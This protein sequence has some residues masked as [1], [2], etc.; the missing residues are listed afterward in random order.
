MYKRAELTKSNRNSDQLRYTYMYLQLSS[1]QVECTYSF[2][3]LYWY[4]LA[5]L[6]RMMERVR[7]RE[8]ESG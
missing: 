3:G 2:D 6:L 8:R 4:T 5:G 1:L 7:K